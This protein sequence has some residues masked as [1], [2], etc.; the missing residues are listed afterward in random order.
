MASLS[1]PGKNTL[2]LV[3]LVMFGGKSTVDPCAYAEA[4]GAPWVCVKQ[5]YVSK[6]S[7]VYASFVSYQW[8]PISHSVDLFEAYQGRR[9]QS[10]RCHMYFTILCA[11]VYATF[12]PWFLAYAPGSDS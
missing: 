9:S 1:W 8:P 10:L 7:Q 6:A 5:A 2:L 4:S 11:D 12:H 3:L